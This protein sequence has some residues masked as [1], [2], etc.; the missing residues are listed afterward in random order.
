MTKFVAAA[1][2]AAVAEYQTEID[3]SPLF[4]W[5]EFKKIDTEWLRYGY[6]EDEA[7]AAQIQTQYQAAITRNKSWY[8]RSL[9]CHILSGSGIVYDHGDGNY[10]VG[11]FWPDPDDPDQETPVFQISHF[12]PRTL[13]GGM[14]MLA[15]LGEL[16]H[17]PVVA[18]VPLDKA[19]MLQRLGWELGPS[20]PHVHPEM[21][22]MMK[23]VCFNRAAVRYVRCHQQWF[24]QLL[25]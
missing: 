21:G 8:L 11:F 4:W 6:A 16:E 9:D 12:A 25:R 5:E 24:D 23:H 15:D 22:F 14:S 20:F 10:L 18:A 1:I 19:E 2:N 17:E 7:I 13:R 3:P